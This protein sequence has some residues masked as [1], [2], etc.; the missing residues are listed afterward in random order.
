VIGGR[1]GFTLPQRGVFFGVTTVAEM[2]ALAVEVDRNELFGSIWVGDSLLAKPRPDSIALLGGLAT[3]T[4]RI[5]LGVG[6]MA[7]FPVRD[8][9]IF[10]YEWATLDLLSAGRMLLAACTGLVAGGAS[11]REGSYWGV[12]DRDRALRLEENI[13]ICR[14]LWREDG[15]SFKGKFRSFEDVTVRPH[16]VQHP[17][18][19]W[20]ASNP[21]PGVTPAIVDRA[22]ERVARLADGWMTVQLFPAMFKTNWSKIAA[23]LRADGRDPASFPTMVYYNVNVNPDRTAALA[24]SA[25]FLAEY[26]GPV[27]TPAMVETWTAAGTAAE[28]AE[29]LTALFRD[30]VASV[31]LRITAWNQTEQFKRLVGEVLPRVMVR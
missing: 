7:S 14:R 19:I 28:C 1:F 12:A 8:P 26:Y 6:C 24:E 9:I 11:A 15:V 18:P 3:A 30:G 31:T 21:R 10:A 5:R 4:V 13:E 17:C 25:R 29:R 27:F 23:Y 16:P 2:M 20:I 22:L